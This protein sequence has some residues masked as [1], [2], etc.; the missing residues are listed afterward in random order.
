MEV[1]NDIPP[2]K[3]DWPQVPD[4]AFDFE[5]RNIVKQNEV[6]LKAAM[7]DFIDLHMESLMPGARFSDTSEILHHQIRQF[8]GFLEKAIRYNLHKIYVVHGLGKGV[9]KAEIEKVLKEYPEVDRYNNDYHARFG[10]G[11]TEIFLD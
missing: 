2:K 4:T 10:F 6:E 8:K 9:L 11:A 5:K 7:P 1:W 3:T